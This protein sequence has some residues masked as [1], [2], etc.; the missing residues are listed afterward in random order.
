MCKEMERPLKGWIVVVIG[1]I[2]SVLLKEP[3][4][5]TISVTAL[6][7]VTTAHAL[8]RKGS[9]AYVMK[10]IRLQF[11]GLAC[12]ILFYLFSKELFPHSL[13][14]QMCMSSLPALAMG[15]LLDYRFK[16]GTTYVLSMGVTCLVLAA[17]L[18][19]KSF[20]Y[21][22]TRI[23]LLAI[24]GILGYVIAQLTFPRNRIKD[25]QEPLDRTYALLLK[26]DKWAND[27][28]HEEIQKLAKGIDTNLTEV[29]SA[30][31]VLSNDHAD[32]HVKQEVDWQELYRRIYCQ[33]SLGFILELLSAQFRDNKKNF[34]EQTASAVREN[35]LQIRSLCEQIVKTENKEEIYQHQNKIIALCS[36]V[37]GLIINPF[38]ETAENS[39]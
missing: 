33:R 32:G 15:L 12:V 10:R 34:D 18:T 39:V 26:N 24:G 27:F 31:S 17:G 23:I 38:F 11:V 3:T 19:G 2:L 36:K 37:Y 29:L 35:L 13:G 7:V 8:P 16:V 21:A 30:I 28:N 20:S 22:L 9:R 14:I 5:I 4:S 6:L 25:V 1:Q